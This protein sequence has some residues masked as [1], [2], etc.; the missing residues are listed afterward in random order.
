MG[1]Q[2]NADQTYSINYEESPVIQ[3]IFEMFLDGKSYKEIASAL[4]NLGYKTRM[5]RTFTKNSIHDILRNEK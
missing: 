1:Y 3:K 4:N 5:G 2:V